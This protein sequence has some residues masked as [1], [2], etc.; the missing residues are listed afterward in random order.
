[1]IIALVVSLAIHSWIE[2]GVI[3]G[4][5][6]LN[7][8]VGFMQQYTAEQTMYGLP[9]P[10]SSATPAQPSPSS[11]PPSSSRATSSSSSLATSSPPSPE[12]RLLD[13]T[14]LEAD[15]S[16]LTG[17]S[18]PVPKH[19]HARAPTQ[20]PP[21][22][23]VPVGDRLNGMAHASSTVTKGRAQGVVVATGMRTEIG[24]GGWL[25]VVAAANRF[26]DDREV[27]IYAV[28]TGLCM[29]PASLI[30]VLTI[31]FAISMKR[32][33]ARRVV[34]RK[35]DSVEALGAVSDVCSDKT[36]TLTQGRMVAR[37]VWVP[38]VGTW[39]LEDSRDPFNTH[40]GKLVF[41]DSHVRPRVSKVNDGRGGGW[42]GG[43][44]A[45]E[46]ELDGLLECAALCNIASVFEEHAA[47]D[48]DKP[49]GTDKDK[50]WAARGDPTEIVLQVL[51]HR[52][53]RGRPALVAQG[54]EQLAEY[55]RVRIRTPGEPEG[56]RALEAGDRDEIVGRVD[57]MAESGLRVL[58][59]AGREWEWEGCRGAENVERG[60]VERDM[61]FFGLVGIYD[62][63]RPES[64]LAVE[65]CRRA[66][67]VVHMLTGDHPSTATA[68]AKEIGIVED[69]DVACMPKH[70]VA[71]ASEFDGLS[72]GEVDKMEELP[73][74]IGRCSPETKVRMIEALHR[75]KRFAAMTGDGMNDSSSLSRAD[76][77]IGMGSGS[78][79]AKNASD[80][81]L[82]DD[83]FA[84]II[85]VI[86]EG[87]RSFDNIKSFALHLLA[88]NVGQAIVLMVGLAFKDQEDLSV[89][90]L[91]PVEVLW[92]V[93]VTSGPPAMGL[94]MQDAAANVMRRP[95]HDARRG[96]MTSLWIC[97]QRDFPLVL[98]SRGLGIRRRRLGAGGCNNSREDCEIV[99]R[100]RAT[101]FAT[102]SWLCLLLAWEMLDMRRSVFWMHDG[103]KNPWMQW[104][105]DLWAN[106]L[107]VLFW[108][109]V[110]GFVGTL[111]VTYLPVI[112]DKVFL[113][114]PIS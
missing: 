47:P 10:P 74:V 104:T 101:C 13:A 72:D 23:Q 32:M 85:A 43:G 50:A 58:A 35:L 78:D 51:A 39:T 86:R 93:V 94:G 6:L 111:V 22:P 59:L 17:E 55:A 102:T 71:T 112:N 98:R 95:P 83:N 42:G 37:V 76:V 64:R 16:L 49:H 96:I 75:R 113:H 21:V 40:D 20:Y 108:S 80:I 69:K 65:D 54:Y 106:Q 87:R 89:F 9:P 24:R 57:G 84:S 52:F 3:A 88:G 2:G 53:S 30:V 15:E 7:V 100:A 56:D 90:P 38:S 68:I 27:V 8:A 103:A 107:Q 77:G 48:N 11:P 92:I 41:S 44:C 81:V 99:F 114:A 109:V 105:K 12:L 31:T 4:V 62:P 63:P 91:S 45:S 70:T 73:R 28:S 19:A 110:L 67:I 82:T 26:V 61:V 25:F 60:E 34:V 5:I 18:L 36:G 97:H 14:N 79:V 29:I 66:G 1:M 33:A 46:K